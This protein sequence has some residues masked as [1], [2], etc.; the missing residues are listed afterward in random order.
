MCGGP[1]FV[2]G[3]LT[4][5]FGS[6]FPD[7]VPGTT[8]VVVLWGQHPS[9]S[10]PP[11][12]GLVRDAMRAGAQLIVV[13]TRPTLEAKAADLWLQPRPAT[14]AALAL[15]VLNAV[16]AQGLC[17]RDFV[18]RWTHGFDDLQER[19][20]SFTPDWAAS[21]TGVPADTTRQLARLYAEAPAA[22]LSAGTPNGQG[23]NAMN[24]ERALCMLVAI[25]GKVD[26]EGLQ[27]DSRPD[28][29]SRKRDHPRRVRGAS[30]ER[31]HETA[32]KRPLQAARRRDRDPQ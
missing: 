13:D 14:D 7:V 21:I 23:R 16:L 27:P 8:N 28:A 1:Q 30:A 2:A 24:L 5:G 29:R 9:A 17:D 15:A 6:A 19:I 22:A 18:D 25:S 12:W 4:F 3:A 31:S 26:R 32:R 10:S 11:Y 20:A